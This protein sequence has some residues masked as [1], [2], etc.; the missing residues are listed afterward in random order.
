VGARSDDTLRRLSEALRDVADE[1]LPVVLEEARAGARAR[2][3]KVLEDA[4]VEAIVDRA[5][6]RRTPAPGDGPSG[7]WVYGVVAA[8]DAAGLSLGVAGVEPGTKVEWVVDGDLVALA[9]PV[10]LSEYDDERLREHLND[11]GWV[12]RTALAHEAVLDAALPNA[13][14]VPL[15]LCTIYRDRVGVEKMLQSDREQL[16]AALER[17]RGRSEWGVKVFASRARIAEIT[18]TGEGADDAARSDAAQYLERKRKDRELA[19][20]VDRTTAECAR[21]CH[22]RLAEVAAAARVNPSQRPEAHGRDADMVL[23]GV[24]LVADDARPAFD[25][26]VEALRAEYGPLGFELDET[27]PWPAYNFVASEAASER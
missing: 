24:Y 23:N 13:P 14:V 12:E 21:D 1:D 18:R 3:A 7:W 26:A 4:L 5:A 9:S 11:L 22:E 16:T 6:E 15:R 20:R 8:A 2:A 25:S 10:P 19:D 27:G 17:L